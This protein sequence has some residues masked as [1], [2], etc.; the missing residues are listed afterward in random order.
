MSDFDSSAPL[1]VD[2]TGLERSLSGAADMAAN[3]DSE[4]KRVQS[5]M[6]TT[7]LGLKELE[8]SLSRSL[9]GAL[10]DIAFDGKKLSEA[11]R[12]IGRSMATTAL[13]AAV[14]PIA[15]HASNLIT[16]SIGTLVQGVFPG[17]GGALARGGAAPA[18][19][20][21]GGAVARGGVM[22]VLAGLGSAAASTLGSLL[23]FAN[24]AP[25]AQGRVMP[26]ALG[27]AFSQ[28]Q[29]LPFA[30]GAPMS[31]GRVMPFA[32][33][34]AF[35]HGKVLPF[36]DGGAFSQGRVMP[37]ASGGAFSHGRLLPFASGGAFSQGRL[38]PFANGGSF[39]QGRIAPF[40][41]GEIVSA[42]TTFPMRGATGLMGEAG[43]EAIMPLKR[44]A[45]GK[46]GV[47]AQG[48]GA[49]TQ[50]VVIN[51]S[52]PDVAGFQRSQTQIAA[53]MSR[54]LGRAQRAR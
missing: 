2:L 10:Q 53:Q 41:S 28:G 29:V 8:T 11:L 9:K 19:P 5:T 15:S 48:G 3:F 27:G 21:A 31:Q 6:A 44:G 22:P 42:P 35:S 54:V 12:D 37:F 49:N 4:M 34:G 43:P 24:G 52:T 7:N 51:I 20:V 45:D 33:G 17:L 16:N 26:F 40:A 13:N 25:M 18:A 38:L 50:N 39:S 1:D 14:K 30:N 36:A 46:L 23:P 47:Q 32:Q